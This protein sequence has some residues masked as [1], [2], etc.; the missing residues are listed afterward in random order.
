MRAFIELQ[1]KL[2]P[3]YVQVLQKRYMLLLSIQHLQPI[4]RRALAQVMNSTERILRAEVDTLKESGLLDVTSLGMSVTE[5]GQRLLE[6]AELI[7]G[8]LFGLTELAARLQQRLNIP[9]VIVVHGDADQSD[10]VKRELGRIGARVIRQRVQED[11]VVAVTGGSS[12]AS[13]AAQLKPAPV[14]RSVQFVPARGGVGEQA[15]LQANMLVSLM[16]ANTGAQ[17]RLFHVPD[18]LGPDAVQSLLAE[19]Q[20]VEVLRLLQSARIILHGIGDALTMAKRRKYAAREL[21][22]LERAGA[23][24]EAFGY[25]FDERGEVV[26]R[27]PT[28]GLQLDNVKE[29]EVVIS[30]AGGASKAK[31]ILSFAAQSCQNVLITDEGAAR[32]ILSG[33]D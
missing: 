24:A 28:L 25:Y 9:E 5:E 15:E 29:A 4:G 20:V 19:P 7:V 30:I 8:E 6:Q 2:V 11:D 21:E 23:V 32:A 16:A 26:E 22:Q 18:R 1:T 17:Y 14:F 13:V 31:A 3:D 12:I 10:L 27:M 33:T